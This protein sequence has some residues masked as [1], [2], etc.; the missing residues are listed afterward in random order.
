MSFYLSA[1]A[2]FAAS[3]FMKA[4][5]FTFAVSCLNNAKAEA[6]K[7]KL[8]MQ[9]TLK[10]ATVSVILNAVLLPL[11]RKFTFLDTLYTKGAIALFVTAIV[12]NEI[13]TLNLLAKDPVEENL[14]KQGLHL[15]KMNKL[16]GIFKKITKK[17]R[18]ENE[19]LVWNRKKQQLECY[20]MKDGIQEYKVVPYD[21]KEDEF[22]FLGGK[23]PASGVAALNDNLHD[24]VHFLTQKKFEEIKQSI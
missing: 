23:V 15:A 21:A 9:A 4:L 2:S 22:A 14:K 10:S 16:S 13:F 17:G 1:A 7:V 6:G 18:S 20:Y 8:I 24:S 19:I 12:S 5:P 3:N 11:S